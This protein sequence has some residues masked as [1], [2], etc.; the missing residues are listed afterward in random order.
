MINQ[1]YRNRLTSALFIVAFIFSIANLKAQITV[2]FE[3]DFENG[4]GG[5]VSI[6]NDGID[7]ADGLVEELGIP[8]SPSQ[9]TIMT[10]SDENSV[11]ISPSW[12][13][14]TGE[15]DDWLITPAIEIL[16][17]TILE[18][19]AEALNPSFRDGYQVLISSNST[20]LGDFSPITEIQAE[21]AK[22]TLRLVDLAAYE[23]QEIYIAFRNNSVN[24]YA[25]SLDEIRVRTSI[26]LDLRV[27]DVALTNTTFLE[28]GFD[29]DAGLSGPKQVLLEVFNVGS[30]MITEVSFDIE[31]ESGSFEEN[32][33]FNL[34]P[35]Q[36]FVLQST[37][38]LDFEVGEQ[39][40]YTISKIMAN[41]VSSF[42]ETV[43]SEVSIFPSVP[44]YEVIGSKGEEVNIHQLLSKNKTVV[45]DFFASWCTPCEIT[46][47][48]LNAWY[49]ENG[50]GTGDLEVIGIDIEPSDD[51]DVVNSLG[52]GATYPKVAFTP[53][54]ELYRLHFNDIH[55]L[56]A[57]QL[58]YF[59]ML[60]PNPENVADSEVRVVQI[61]IPQPPSFDFWQPEVDACISNLTSTDNLDILDEEISIFPNPSN[62]VFYVGMNEVHDNAKLTLVSLSG[63]QLRS[64][65][66]NTDSLI[67]VILRDLE[68]GIYMLKISL[69]DKYEVKKI[70]IY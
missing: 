69:R 18:W 61:G 48:L 57:G 59:V 38:F 31:T 13:N 43:V 70:I 21:E 22:P 25:I 44:D 6:D 20:D 68:K 50:S 39:Q 30:E 52:W 45:L 58:P 37:T 55:G 67:Q 66:T 4:L 3:Q 60:C 35:G 9:W 40:Q 56:N 28:A 11:A 26:P 5:M 46:T 23:G 63:Q 62:G 33:V 65:D 16:P 32:H 51:A 1:V 17:E 10:V 7:V 41:G 27:V 53:E 47:P 24:K 12:L 64:I 19:K 8:V 42:P 49:E 29:I 34:F 2:L 14:P 54:N 15:A 36:S